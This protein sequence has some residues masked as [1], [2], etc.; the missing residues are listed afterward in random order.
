MRSFV[1]NEMVAIL[2]STQRNKFNLDLRSKRH[3]CIVF[4]V[5]SN[6]AGKTTTISKLT[7]LYQNQGRKVVLVAGDTTRAAA[8]EQLKIWSERTNTK[9]FTFQPDYQ[10]TTGWVD[11]L[12]QQI[13]PSNSPSSMIYNAVNFCETHRAYDLM[14]VDTAGRLQD[15][16]ANMNSLENMIKMTNKIRKDSPDYTWLVLDSTVG[17]S[18]LD[19]AREFKRRTRVNGIIITKM[20]G[21]SKGGCLLAIC[22]DLNIPICYVTKGENLNDIELFDPQKYVDAIIP[23]EED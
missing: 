4:I 11:N 16:I 19:V 8:T 15:N 10:Q 3:P 13:I 9:I 2:N 5:G 21:T 17:Q 18:S 12:K 14:F 6:G 1:S 7:N 23:K 20:D 22:A